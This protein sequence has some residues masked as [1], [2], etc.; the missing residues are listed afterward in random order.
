MNQCLS[1]I[2]GIWGD[3]AC[4]ECARRG[5]MKLKWTKEKPTK[6][7][8]YWFRHKAFN[9]YIAKVTCGGTILFGQYFNVKDINNDAEWAGPIP[10]PEEQQ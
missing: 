3:I 10:E 2:P 6:D 5:K 7:G 9:T 4:D 8:W 1:C